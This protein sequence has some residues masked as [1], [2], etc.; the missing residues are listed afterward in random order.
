MELPE[1]RFLCGE[2]AI[3]EED[4]KPIVV[5][6]VYDQEDNGYFIMFDMF[7]ITES[8]VEIPVPI[9]N[10]TIGFHSVVLQ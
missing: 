2:P 9:K 7:N 5:G 6:F 10:M 4:G 1:N 8:Y 3:I